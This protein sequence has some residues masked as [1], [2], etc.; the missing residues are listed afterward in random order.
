VAKGADEGEAVVT[1]TF[2]PD[3][4]ARVRRTHTMLA[5]RIGLDGPRWVIE[6]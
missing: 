6:A 2:D 1:A 5:D 3:E 4:L